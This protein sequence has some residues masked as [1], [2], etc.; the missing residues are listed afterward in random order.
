[1]YTLYILLNYIMY[2]LYCMHVYKFVHQPVSYPEEAG[3]SIGGP[4]FSR[5]IM[6]EVHYNN[7]EHKKGLT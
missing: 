4:G 6:L 7:P 3:S 2:T 5:Y 1:M